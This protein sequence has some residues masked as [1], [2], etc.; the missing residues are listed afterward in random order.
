MSRSGF[1][2]DYDK[3][4]DYLQRSLNVNPNGMDPN[5]FYGEFLSERGKTAQAIEYLRKAMAAPARAGHEDAE[6]GR[7]AEIPQMLD[8]LMK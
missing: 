2:G 1:F 3:T 8:T 6:A 4:R 7:H 5:F